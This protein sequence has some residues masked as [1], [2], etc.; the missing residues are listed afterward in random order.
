[1][2][3]WTTLVSAR[4]LA[5]VYGAD[6]V[7]IIDCRFSLA[8]PDAGRMAYRAG[9]I[10]GAVY[11]HL[12]DDLSALPSSD[13]ELGRH[14]MPTVR[15]MEA[16]FR[17]LGVD[18]GDQVVAYDD[19]GGAIA[20]RLWWMLRY[21][22]H[23]RVAVLDGGWQAWTA[24]GHPESAEVGRS[25]AGDFRAHP[26]AMPVAVIHDLLRGLESRN[27]TMLDA[28]DAERYTGEKE[29]IDPVAGHIPGARSIPF[30]QNLDAAGK[31]LPQSALRERFTDFDTPE[32]LAVSYCGSGVTACHNILAMEHAGLRPAALFPPSWSGWIAD[33]NRPLETGR[34][35][36]PGGPDGE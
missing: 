4:D 35:D 28:R 21:L 10:P 19:S 34:P 26:G 15:D 33:P 13:P 30:K 36:D 16:T 3:A 11:A 32:T 22:G 18:N 1:M 6:G 2:N 25:T 12:D 24:G 7:R 29:P 23:E 31:F 5:A 20:S 14:P 9:H 27:V 17:R 8:D